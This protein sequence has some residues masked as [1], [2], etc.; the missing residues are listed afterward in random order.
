MTI[1]DVLLAA[2][3]TLTLAPASAGAARAPAPQRVS[4]PAQSLALPRAV[5]RTGTQNGH[6]SHRLGL[7]VLGSLLVVAG[8]VPAAIVV[9]DAVDHASGG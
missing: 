3:I 1:S 2:A 5:I 9:Q 8:A 6:G 4:S 7:N